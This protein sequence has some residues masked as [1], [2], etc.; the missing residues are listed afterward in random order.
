MLF[1]RTVY[2]NSQ[3][4]TN[5]QRFK[6]EVRCFTTIVRPKIYFMNYELQLGSGLHYHLSFE[7]FEVWPR[8]E[9]PE[10]VVIYTGKYQTGEVLPTGITIN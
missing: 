8:C 3:L 5:I 4:S 2:Y 9:T 7:D 1:G 10:Q 6:L